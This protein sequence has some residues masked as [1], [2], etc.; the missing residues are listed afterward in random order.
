MPPGAIQQ[1]SIAG[2]LRFRDLR[3]LT[4]LFALLL[5]S[6]PA[7]AQDMRDLVEQV[8][9]HP[10]ENVQIE[11][12]PLPA[13]LEQ[14]GQ[15]TGLIFAVDE[16]ALQWMP[17]G[18]QTQISIDLANVTLRAGLRRMFAGLGLQMRVADS[19]V[20]VEP[21]PVLERLGR[22]LTLD[23]IQ[24]LGRLASASWE[25][26]GPHQPPLQLAGLDGA[27]PRET[28]IDGM[29]RVEAAAAME[30]LERATE[31]R[32]WVWMPNG[33]A[34]QVYPAR[35]DVARRLRRTVSLE[36][37]GA[38]LDEVLVDLG[39]RVGIVMSFT[40]GVL[41]RLQASRRRVHLI[42]PETTV[43]QALELIRGS[44]GVTFDVTDAGVRIDLPAET[45]AADRAPAGESAAARSSSQPPGQI[46]AILRVPVGLGGVTVEFPFYAENLPP[47]FAEFRD[48]KV[49][50]VIEALR[51]RMK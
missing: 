25:E 11:G 37:Q 21:A 40:P 8:L 9:D 24:L 36:Y 41:D 35:E 27:A 3:P 23:E 51:E 43:L 14:L 49:P 22:R 15:E 33:D 47:E 5:L 46:L 30:Q 17:Y 16:R 42:Q 4:T 28:L 18:A 20:V 48:Q 12:M 50:E 34:V 13:A 32:G 29:H 39:R 31:T 44:T 38:P 10:A 45:G 6:V 1:R 26:L 7:G 2:N 19:Q